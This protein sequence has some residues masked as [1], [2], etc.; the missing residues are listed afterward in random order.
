MLKYLEKILGRLNKIKSGIEINSFKWELLPENPELLQQV[1]D[2]IKVKGSEIEKLKAELSKKYSEAR[3][4]SFEKQEL[5]KRLE[6][7]AVGI[8]AENPDKLSDY[9]ISKK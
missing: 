1:I 4:I 6:K 8:H 2:E 9:G 3:N 7:R 5:I